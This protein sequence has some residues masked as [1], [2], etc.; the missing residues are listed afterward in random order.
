[1]TKQD[2]RLAAL[3][4]SGRAIDSLNMANLL[5]HENR[6]LMV[7][8]SENSAIISGADIVISW[9][10]EGRCRADHESAIEFSIDSDS[11]LPYDA[12]GCLAYDLGNDPKQ[13]HRIRPI[14]V[15][16]DGISKKI[17][18]P[19][20]R[21]LSK[22]ERFSVLVTSALPGCMRYGIDYYT[23]TFS[24]SQPE[25]VRC[26]IHLVFLD[27]RPAWVRVYDQDASGR[28]TELGDLRPTSVHAK[29]TEYREVMPNA[30]PRSARVYLFERHEGT[31]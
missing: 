26:I 28:V 19:F 6:S 18:I 30:S 27:E 11:R 14:L 25:A 21:P 12:I 31:P 7:E 10:C 2:P 29:K 23:A 22:N 16:P 1:M 20:L 3:R 9:R 15:G 17:S 13:Q 24:F 8:T 5:R 4:L